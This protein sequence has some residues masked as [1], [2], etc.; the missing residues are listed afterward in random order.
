MFAIKYT[1]EFLKMLADHM[2]QEFER[3][4]ENGKEH[5]AI[6]AGQRLKYNKSENII[7]DLKEIMI[8]KSHRRANLIEKVNKNITRELLNI[9]INHDDEEISIAILTLLPGVQVP[10][11]SAILTILFPEKYTVLDVRAL[12][13]LGY[14]GNDRTPEFY[15]KYL[16]FCREYAEKIGFEIHSN[17]LNSLRLL[18]KA[19]FYANGEDVK[20]IEKRLQGKTL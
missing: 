16:Y 10:M 8:W 13:S 18:D 2:V 1:N 14:S 6:K 7:H 4:G 15:K 3:E 19:L 5:K 17:Y 12:K 9:S 20:Q 11:S